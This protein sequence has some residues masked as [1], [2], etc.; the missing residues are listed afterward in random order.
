M[1]GRKVLPRQA[2]D[3]QLS[4]RS[5]LEAMGLL[6]AL[7]WALGPG[8]AHAGALPAKLPLLLS[9]VFHHIAIAVPD[10]AASATFYSQL[11]GGD[12]LV[13]RQPNLCYIVDC[14]PGKAAGGE[15]AGSIAISALDASSPDI[16]KARFHHLGLQAEGYDDDAWRAR[17]IRERLHDWSQ[18][19][20]GDIDGIP[21]RIVG[22]GTDSG[23]S[24]GSTLSEPLHVTEPLLRADGFDHA[25]LRVWNV[26][27]TVAFYYRMFGL[28]PSSK[29]TDVVWFGGTTARVGLRQVSGGE[30]PGIDHCAIRVAGAERS[31]IN[32]QLH[33]LGATPVPSTK[34]EPDDIVR[35]E[36]PDGLTVELKLV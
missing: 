33:A 31:S 25:L 2:A 26:E 36:D 11:L 13:R 15:F 34:G 4:R 27:K 35:F 18:G 9:S 5:L 16:D 7:P 14:K 6:T 8:P 30:G 24:A 3:P 23:L 17:L 12:V 10:P 19:V 28:S 21:M 22:T 29:R 32:E 20:F 1:I